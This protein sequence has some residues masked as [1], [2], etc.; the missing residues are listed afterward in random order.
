[1]SD[2]GGGSDLEDEFEN[3]EVLSEGELDQVLPGTNHG[4]RQARPGGAKLRVLRR[5][6]ERVRPAAAGHRG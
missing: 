5:G 2:K 6:Q 1:M 4:A 3:D